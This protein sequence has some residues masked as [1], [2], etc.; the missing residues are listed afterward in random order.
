MSLLG[1]STS[2]FHLDGMSKHLGP[3]AT[4]IQ[5]KEIK[6][7][8]V[9]AMKHG[10]KNIFI[11]GD[12]SDTPKLSD[13]SFIALLTLLLTYDDHLLV[14]YVMGNHDFYHRGKNAFDVLKVFT[15]AGLF[16]NFKV[17]GATE[18]EKIDGVYVCY[19]P[20]PN[21]EV[22][23]TKRPSLV[24]AHT[25]T[26]GA[27]GDNGMPLKK[28]VDDFIRQPGDFVIS[29]HIHQY[30]HLKKKRWLYNGS[31]YQKNFGEALPKG[32]VEFE[33]KYVGGKL[34]VEHDL[35]QNKP[36]F[37]LETVLVKTSEDWEALSPH[38][39]K[40]YR[41]LIDKAE[42]TLPKDISTRFPNI[43][44]IN[45]IDVTNKVD[46]SEVD[47]TA[48]EALTL[49]NLPKVS[50]KTG[51]VSYLKQS[52]LSRYKRDMAQSLVSEAIKIL[53]LQ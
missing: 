11:P 18:I 25:E 46:M 22:P 48:L 41:L 1:I 34:K 12:A 28:K 39:S 37:T 33:A 43:V 24:F 17:I 47:G 36:N 10:I 23:A 21:L 13:H 8:F 45:G 5:M 38:P 4:E 16:K 50:V 29:G 27:I 7:P 6:K 35:I 3:N 20:Y 32:F 31:L 40:R 19:V 51:L 30:Q 52:G 53:N 9:Y 2:D 26:V 14:R 15:D 49:K 42:V 44:S